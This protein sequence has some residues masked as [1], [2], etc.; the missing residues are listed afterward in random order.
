MLTC[1]RALGSAF[2]FS[3]GKNWFAESFIERRLATEEARHQEIEQTPKFEDIILDWRPGQDESM[4]GLNLFDGLSELG[5]CVLDDMAFVEDAVKPVCRRQLVDVVADHIVRS[6]YNV[7][8]F[9]GRDVLSSIA[10]RA[11]VKQGLQ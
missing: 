11:S 2:A 6:N 4:L 5:F 8:A 1:F 10:G 9:D 7:V 3:V